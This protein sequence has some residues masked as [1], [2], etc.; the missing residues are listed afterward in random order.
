MHTQLK[1]SIVRIF[2][3]RGDIV[4]MGFLASERSILSCAHV[5]TAA[6]NIAEDT[7][8]V[9][10][11][12]IS[13]DF[14]L[15][16]PGCYLSAY[17]NFWQPP[18]PNGGGDIAVLQL[19]DAAPAGA[20]AVHLV[21]AEDMWNRTF[22]A[23]GFPGGHDAGVWV[24]GTLRDRQ[25][26]GWVQI[27]QISTTGYQVQQGFSGGPVWDE[28][29]DGVVGIVVAEERDPTIRAAYMIPTNVLVKAWPPLE[30]QARSPCPYRGLFPFQEQDVSVFFGRET[31]TDQLVEAVLRQSSFAIV[32]GPSGSG[33]SSVVFAGLF[34]RLRKEST[35]LLTHLRPGNAPFQA[36][37]TALLLLL[38]QEMT[39]TDR[40]IEN[41][42]L[43]TALS[44]GDLSITEVVERIVQKQQGS[45]RVLLAIDQ[46]EELYTLCPEPAIRQQFLDALVKAVEAQRSQQHSHMTVVLT[47]RADFLGQALAQRSFADVL[48]DAAL[49][50][51]PMTHV[52]LKTAIEEP[53]RQIGVTFAPGLV[54]RIVDDVENEPGQLPLLEFALTLLWERQEKKQLTHQAYEEIGRVEGALARYA[55]QV[56]EALGEDEKEGVRRV[57]IQMV[58]PGEH[59]EDTRRLATRGELGEEGWTLARQ[60]SDKRLVVTNVT[61]TGQETA[62]IV[63]EALIQRWTR[64][65]AWMNADRTFREWQ[66]RL[67][68]TL[69][70]W[71]ESKQDEG[72][73]LHGALLTEAKYWL[74][75]R[76]HEL[77]LKER[78]Y[79]FYSI[80]NEGISISTWLHRYGT[81]GETL[82]F[83]DTYI[84]SPEEARR[85]KSIEALKCLPRTDPD[86]KV[87]EQLQ[88]SV[89]GDASVAVRS[90]AAHAICER[91]QISRLTELLASKGLSIQERQRV[92]QALASTRNQPGTGLEVQK[93]L[94]HSRLRVLF[95]ATIQLLLDYRNTLAIIVFFSFLLGQIAS[96]LAD[97]VSNVVESGSSLKQVLPPIGVFQVVMILVLGLYVFIRRRLIDGKA[98]GLKECIGI[99]AIVAFIADSINYTPQIIAAVRDTNEPVITAISF[100]LLPHLLL[101]IAV[102]SI[103][104]LSFRVHLRNRSAAWILFLIAILS[105]GIA[106]LSQQV[107]A[108]HTTEINQSISQLSSTSIL[109]GFPN[110][111]LNDIFNYYYATSAPTYPI[112]IAIA[113]FLGFCAVF[114]CLL[115]FLIGFRSAFTGKQ[116]PVTSSLTT[117]KLRVAGTSSRSIRIFS[118]RT[119]MIVFAGLAIA[120]VGGNLL[121]WT[122]LHRPYTYH[123]DS[124]TVGS[125]NWS[126]DDKYLAFSTS[127]VPG[128]SSMSTGQTSTVQ[129]WVWN[130]I[131]KTNLPLYTYTSNGFPSADITWSH[132]GKYLAFTI[133]TVPGGSSTSTAQTFTGQVWVWNAITKAKLSLYTY[134]TTT[135]TTSSSS[136]TVGSINWSPDDKYL[137]FSTSTVPGGLLTSTGQTSTAQVWVW[138]AITKAKLSLY[139]YTSN[140]FPSADITWS[141][142]G[143]YLAFTISTYPGGLSTSTAQT[144]TGRVWVWNATTKAK[145]S[146]YTYT[147]TTTTSSSSYSSPTVGSITWSPDDKYLAFSTSTVPGGSSTSTG[148]TSTAQ[149][150]VWN[151]ITKAKLSLYTT[152][153]T[154]SPTV[155]NITWSPDDKY[156]AFSTSTYSGGS[157]TSTGQTS[158][159]QVWVWNAITKTN[160]PLYTYTSN[161]FP[162]ADIT[163]SH[164]GK[165]LAFTISTYPGGLSTST[166]QAWV[167]NAITKAKLSLYTYTST[168]TTYTSSSP[169]VGSIIWSPD[170]KYLA[171]TTSTVP[172]GSL[173]STLQMS[174]AQVWVWNA[175]TKAKLSLYTTTSTSA[176]FSN[177]GSPYADMTWSP[178]NKHFAFVLNSIDPSC[179]T[180]SKSDSC[181]GTVH[182][183]DATTKG[184]IYTLRLS[185]SAVE[186]I[187]WS[188]D[189][190]RIAS[191]SSDGTL[192]VWYAV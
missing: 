121:W 26:T 164:D 59:T 144:F 13:L 25:A 190:T 137:A 60:L 133:S 31:F 43:A 85:L 33:K 23:F 176:N 110:I 34:P 84:N 16:A 136:P 57:S 15:I 73:L 151:A 86:D 139:T 192:N 149:V 67:R 76:G 95:V 127:T 68:A 39:E 173:T 178:D 40:L 74:E 182:I 165:Y 4:G 105:A 120:V 142:D 143:K 88:R 102:A 29:L 179:E 132:D 124:P 82:A 168:S 138:N 14:P 78:D 172:G 171:F 42:K 115:G 47:L 156:L 35:W 180:T 157:S 109:H 12:A 83:L 160:L 11:T 21:S 45:S 52:D 8:D 155:G 22:R 2:A 75:K 28:E 104:A 37:A 77:T 44:T 162:S 116:A 41:R 112:S 72:V 58:R 123:S 134:T 20:E 117:A 146:L 79:V 169:T 150:W 101:D 189:N 36:L 87:Y 106:A 129:V 100:L 53:A 148:Q 46:F 131:T 17:V 153:T 154:T 107:I 191:G 27:E 108:I 32:L 19:N 135:T 103:I 145:L 64:L 114:G 187:A 177:T 96:S 54:E 89:L 181:N 188:P 141:H 71:E 161:G 158:T 147:T 5:I 38:E 30:Q 61:L 66:E 80:L 152:T 49:M 90:K 170:D 6:L 81:I 175:I 118:R 56:Y 50:L 98:I 119:A 163:W 69:H 48:Q 94:R 183:W 62:E 184:S 111:L 93:A 122:L 128:G 97:Q 113:W 99:G 140:G 55:D 1:A 9:P 166:G 186:S 159:A 174:T 92:I 63:H 3:A 24:P 185:S 91:G 65:Q 70:Q 130:A 126:P 18:Q 125:I 7:P 167:W 10:T 51:T